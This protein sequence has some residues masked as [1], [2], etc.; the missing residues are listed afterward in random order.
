MLRQLDF[1][2]VILEPD[3]DVGRTT[4]FAVLE[5]AD[6]HDFQPVV[7]IWHDCLAHSE[8]PGA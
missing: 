3:T 8:T 1:P 6:R 2:R 7:D 4:Y 5:A